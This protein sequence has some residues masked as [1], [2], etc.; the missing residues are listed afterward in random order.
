MEQQDFFITTMGDPLDTSDLIVTEDTLNNNIRLSDFGKGV[1]KVSFYALTYG[2]SEGFNEPFWEYDPKNRRIEGSLP[3]D[4]AKATTYI[5]KDA[6][7][8]VCEVMFELF[9][10]VSGWVKDFDFEGLKKAM[11]DAVEN[12]PTFAQKTRFRVYSD[13][14]L[15][16][17]DIPEFPGFMDLS[18]Y[19][20]GVQKLFFEVAF[21]KRP[22]TFFPNPLRFDENKRGLYISII[23]GMDINQFSSKLDKA[24]EKLK[25]RVQDFDFD[26]FKSDI[27][28]FTES[29]KEAA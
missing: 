10:K 1:R 16:T 29:L 19:G 8:L 27:L 12:N 25:P 9:D 5:D 23:S 2:D 18:K 26:S 24:I 6:Q 21:F 15:V 28:H 17:G 13:I 20:K 22:E 4:Y 3:L 11:L 14:G 7:K